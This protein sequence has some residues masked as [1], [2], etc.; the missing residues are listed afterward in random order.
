MPLP[1]KHWKVTESLSEKIK[2]EISKYTHTAMGIR[3][4]IYNRHN[5]PSQL[6]EM[7][8][9]C[10]GTALKVKFFTIL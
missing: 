6:Y 5:A 2:K 10:C 8:S 3:R 9:I 1:N 7:C 4:V